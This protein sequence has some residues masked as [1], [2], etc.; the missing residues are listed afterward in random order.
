LL[1]P[2]HREPDPSAVPTELDP[3]GGH[4]LSESEESLQLPRFVP[5]QAFDALFADVG[6]ANASHRHTPIARAYRTSSTQRVPK[7]VLDEPRLIWQFTKRVR[8]VIVD[9]ESDASLHVQHYA[10]LRGPV[11]V[12]KNLAQNSK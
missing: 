9:A 10:V 5:A 11:P 7:G 6:N 3:R 12:S 4:I 8:E 1:I 2:A